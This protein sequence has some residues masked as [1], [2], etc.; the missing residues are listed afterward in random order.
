MSERHTTRR[1]F[2]RTAAAAGAAGLAWSGGSARARAAKNELVFVGFGGSYQEG[3]T[4]ALF[5]PFE[6]ETGIKIIQ[7]TGVDIA[8]LRAQVQSKNVEW[9]LISIPD[10]LRYTAVKDGLL[11]PL[12]YKTINAKDILPALVTEYAVGCVTIPML[13]T[14]STK[15]YPAGK[16]PV[17]WMDY[18]DVKKFPG[19][20]G[21]YNAP[22]YI[23][24]FAL[25]ADGVPKDKLY[26]LDVPR[27]FKS[28][29]RIKGDVKVWWSQF[30]QPGVLLKSGEITMTPWT[31]SISFIQE[32]EPLGI[33]Y[34]GAALTYEAWVVT[35]NAPNAENAM[36]F[37]NW[38]LQAKPQ[39]DLTKYVASAPRTSRPRRSSI[40]SC[41]RCCPPIPRTS[42]RASC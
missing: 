29:D 25:I 8:K 21:M 14:Y 6:K 11:M 13:L 42:R 7:T 18:W 4:K 2:L 5:E 10:R 34:D 33:S 41:G 9:D 15:A 31:R 3:Q 19:P 38:A 17:T 35:K 30:P 28:L 24:E 40:P 26:P 27:A 37:I 20:R 23:L 36:K 16:A 22:T 39:A 1:D 12:D 32:G